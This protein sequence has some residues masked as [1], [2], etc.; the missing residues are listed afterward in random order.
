MDFKADRVCCGRI[1]AAVICIRNSYVAGEPC[2]IRCSKAEVRMP[3]LPEFVLNIRAV[4]VILCRVAAHTVTELASWTDFD[5]EAAKNLDTTEN[6]P[7]V[8]PNGAR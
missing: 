5:L 1:A 4:N 8:E 7:Q 3:C 6:P 2:A